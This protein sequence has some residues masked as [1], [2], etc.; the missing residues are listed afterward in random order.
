M[1]LPTY[2]IRRF[3]LSPP[4]SRT[5]QPYLVSSG[6]QASHAMT[7]V[8]AKPVN[9]IAMSFHTRKVTVEP[10]VPLTDQIPIGANYDSIDIIQSPKHNS[11]NE[12]IDIHGLPA[13]GCF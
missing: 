1:I 12:S 5:Y 7:E 8:Y 9:I 4:H 3:C 13:R 10:S 2:E 6:R 11:D